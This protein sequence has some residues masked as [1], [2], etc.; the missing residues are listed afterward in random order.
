MRKVYA[1]KTADISA[2]LQPSV[3]ISD[4]Q[5]QRSLQYSAAF[6]NDSLT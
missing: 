5:N 1:C 3:N 6:L 2:M 4:L